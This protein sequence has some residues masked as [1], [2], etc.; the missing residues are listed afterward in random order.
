MKA[1]LLTAGFATRLYPLTRDRAKPLLD[2]G[3]RPVLDYLLD[4]VLELDGLDEIL[5]VHNGRFADQFEAWAAG[6]S[7]SVPMRLIND[8]AVDDDTKLG[9]IGDLR[10]ALGS[11]ESDVPLFVGAG[12]N[13]IE[14]DLASY[15]RRFGE[16]PSQPL[17]LVREIEGVVP[18]G[19]YSEVLLEDGRITRFRREARGPR[20]PTCLQWGCTSSPRPLAAGSTSTWADGGNPDAPGHLFAWLCEQHGLR[21]AR[22]IGTWH[23][24]GKPRD[25]RGR[26]RR[27]PRMSDL[28]SV[29]IG[30]VGAGF[31]AETRARCY[32]KAAGVRTRLAAVCSRTPE[33][34]AEYA[35][36]HNVGAICADLDEL[37][38]RDDV[39]LVDLCV[40][41]HPPPALRRARGRRGQAHRLHQAVD[42]IRWPGPP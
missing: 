15:G 8:G 33:K 36:R 12:D 26:T 1:I 10:L 21:G 11:L 5:V 29:G 27:V 39:Q 9:A 2:V 30:I 7:L 16:D 14:V 4:R 31:L 19:R 3:G 34:A 41:N 32:A 20:V 22:L 35:Q 24:I 42:R 13:L 40:P 18:P 28:P 38:A 17:M 23:D 37:L 6:H 25:P